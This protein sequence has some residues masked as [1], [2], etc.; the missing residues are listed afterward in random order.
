[1]SKKSLV[2]LFAII[3]ILGMLGGAILPMLSLRG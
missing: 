1:M 3:G 2:R